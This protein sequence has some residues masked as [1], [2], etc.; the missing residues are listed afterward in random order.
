[1]IPEG[2]GEAKN[3]FEEVD[4]FKAESADSVL[5]RGVFSTLEAAKARIKQLLVS[6]PG[7][8]FTHHQ[9]TGNKIFFKP[10]GHNGHSGTR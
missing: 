1:M 5:W 4:I 9:S 2:N 3:A 10:Y 8:Y 7:E 6:D